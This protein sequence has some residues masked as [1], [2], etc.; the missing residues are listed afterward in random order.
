VKPIEKH[1]R[2]S[3]HQDVFALACSSSRV[4]E[5]V[6]LLQGAFVFLHAPDLAAQAT[7]LGA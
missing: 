4:Q 7:D 6:A 2:V 5:G 1:E 3:R